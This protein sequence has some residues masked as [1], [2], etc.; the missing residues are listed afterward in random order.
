MTEESADPRRNLL[1]R[2]QAQVDEHALDQADAA[3]LAAAEEVMTLWR[4]WWQPAQSV[5]VPVAAEMKFRVI[6]PLATHALNNVAAALTLMRR[7]WVAGVNGRVAF[8][9]AL[10]A[11]WVLLTHGG[12]REI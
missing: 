12:E 8:E 9:Y 10:A 4:R 6:Y 2:L 5:E 1:H 11:Q 3:Y 7:P